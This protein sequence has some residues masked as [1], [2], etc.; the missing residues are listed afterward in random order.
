[1]LPLPNFHGSE[2]T[3][4]LIFW[5]TDSRIIDEQPFL[6]TMLFFILGINEK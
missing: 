5:K 6:A 3:I 1:M 4:A 2:V